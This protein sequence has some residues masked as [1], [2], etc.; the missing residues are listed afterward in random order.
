[1]TYMKSL[2]MAQRC[3]FDPIGKRECGSL[4]NS[5]LL[6][7][8]SYFE[9]FCVKLREREREGQREGQIDIDQREDR[10]TKRNRDRHRY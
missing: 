7:I 6:H 9:P 8:S 3:I 5:I 4:W 1:M 10:G 2:I